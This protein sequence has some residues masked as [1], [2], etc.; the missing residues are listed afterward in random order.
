MFTLPAAV[1][2]EIERC[3]GQ[4]LKYPADCHRLAINVRQTLNET[5]GVT[6]LKRIL[7]FVS[8]VEEP[9]KSTLDILARYCG[10]TD[11]EEMKR[12][13]APGGDSD[14][15]QDPDIDTSALLPGA[16]VRFEYLPDRKVKLRYLGNSEF[17]VVESENGSLQPGDI[18]TV[19]NF[20][21]DSPLTVSSVRRNG[22]D[23]GRY[24]AGKVSGITSLYLEEPDSAS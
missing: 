14:F 7:G 6:T 15:E 19:S 11:Y 5:I 21:K 17:E 24:T 4:P 10:F 20:V 3:Y 9:R 13:V 8:D 18:I 16:V 2:A 23:L 1:K 22:T 12:K